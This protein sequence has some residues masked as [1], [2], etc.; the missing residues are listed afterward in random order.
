MNKFQS[1]LG[2]L[3]LTFRLENRNIC[4]QFLILRIRAPVIQNPLHARLGSG[5]DQFQ[6][7]SFRS[8]TGNCDDQSILALQSLD[9]CLGL[10]IVNGLRDHSGWE[11][12]L[13]TFSRKS[14]YSVFA[15]L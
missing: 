9:N 14:G 12:A 13:A 2:L 11:L 5:R 7:S 6:L 3:I 8:L 10:A 15:G 4:N 1:Y